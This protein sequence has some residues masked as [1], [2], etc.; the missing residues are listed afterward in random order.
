[1]SAP[2]P[3]L[4]AIPTPPGLYF[5]TRDRNADGRLAPLV[6]VW[7]ARPEL[8]RASDVGAYWIGEGGVGLEFRFATWSLATAW[9]VINNAI[10]DDERQCIR[11]GRG[12]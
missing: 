5:V 7:T 1:M 4:P 9:R 8:V 6:E 11:V 10:P 3:K 12:E 2:K